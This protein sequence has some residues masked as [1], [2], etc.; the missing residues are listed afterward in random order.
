MQSALAEPRARR[1]LVVGEVMGAGRAFLR[2]E[3]AAAVRAC[4]L[5]REAARH[6]AHVDRFVVLDRPSPCR[7]AGPF[8]ACLRRTFRR[9]PVGMLPCGSVFSPMSEPDLAALGAA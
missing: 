2:D 1:L 6:L 9:C 4:A 3:V 5:A 7:S 8:V